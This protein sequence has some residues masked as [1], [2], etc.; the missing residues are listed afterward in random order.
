MLIDDDIMLL[1]DDLLKGLDKELDEF[2]DKLL[3]N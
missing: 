1:G 2:L 3:K